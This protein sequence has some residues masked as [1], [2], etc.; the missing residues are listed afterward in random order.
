MRLSLTF[1]LLAIL[2]LLAVALADVAPQVVDNS[3]QLKEV[4]SKLQKLTADLNTFRTNMN[5]IQD[6]N[7]SLLEKLNKLQT[8]QATPVKP[9]VDTA[10][11]TKVSTLHSTVEDLRA[12]LKELSDKVA[13]LSFTSQVSQHLS[14]VKN[15]YNASVQPKAQQLLTA[16]SAYTEKA[17]VAVRPALGKTQMLSARAYH[18]TRALVNGLK[19][20]IVAAVTPFVTQA[21][22]I[23]PEQ[24]PLVLDAIVVSAFFFIGFTIF[25]IAYLILSTIFRLVC[26]CGGKKAAK[27]Q[28]VVK[29]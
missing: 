27:K 18:Y 16:A 15:F 25:I 21:K 5:K 11:Q 10:T 24:R 28:Q 19:P 7:K 4:E 8:A 6:E 17:M 1:A 14:T 20:K 26:C 9:P 12:Q 29:K 23:S 3:A 2:C 13:N 22:F